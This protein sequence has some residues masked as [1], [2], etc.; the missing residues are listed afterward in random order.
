M[1]TNIFCNRKKGATING[2]FFPYPRMSAMLADDIEKKAHKSY[3]RRVRH[4]EVE[5]D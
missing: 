2:K 4:G 1:K 3:Q 5:V